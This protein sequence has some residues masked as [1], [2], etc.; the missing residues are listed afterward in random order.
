MFTDPETEIAS[1]REILLSQFVFFH[2][3]AAFEYFFGFGPTDGYVDGDF[4]VSSNTEG[5]DCVAG[6]ACCEENGVSLKGS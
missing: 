3:Q 5:S 1:R 6:F 4:F 2:F